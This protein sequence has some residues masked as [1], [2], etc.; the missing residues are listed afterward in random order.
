L[1]RLS[2]ADVQRLIAAGALT[3]NGTK[4]KPSHKVRQGDYVVIDLPPD[5]GEKPEPQPIP[6]DI[7]YEDEFIVVINKQPDLIVHPGRGKDNWDGT[8]TNALQY[9]FDRLSAYGGAFRP[10]IVHRL[11]R[12]TSGIIVVAKD[13]LAHRNLALQFERR[14]VHKEYLALCYGAPDR[15]RDYI[16]LPIGR[17]PHIREKMAVRHEEG[18]GKPAKTFYEV[19][20]RFEGFSLVRCVLFTGR[21]H[22]IRVH[23]ES[24]KTPIVADQPY[25]GR[26]ELRLSEL[27]PTAPEDEV[28]LIGRQALHAS[29]LVFRH[30]RCHEEMDFEVPPPPDFQRTL[31]ALRQHRRKT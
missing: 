21:T 16:E 15:D 20:E 22:Q 28:T 25:S 11:D 10:G 3:L 12:D 30:P 23:L 6:L 19:L 24:L 13:D 2:R 17:H 14:K 27:A 26:S 8:M 29:R 31:A 5:L 1:P 18:V 7:V 4:T 9:H